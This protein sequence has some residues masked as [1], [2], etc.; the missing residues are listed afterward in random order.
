[1][2]RINL[3]PGEKAARSR[4]TFM[5]SVPADRLAWLPRSPAFLAGLAGVAVLLVAVF[6][7]FGER[8][9]LAQA[10]A[11]VVEEQADSLQLHRSI[12]R[13]RGLEDTQAR[14]AARIEILDEVVDG[15]LYS[16]DLME[17]L[18]MMLP[19]YTWLERIDQEDLAADQL[20][21]A[22]AT[23]SNAAVTEYMRG[24]EASPQLQRVT[25][26]GVTRSDRNQ[27]PVQ[28]FTLVADFENYQAVIIA[29][30]D[31]TQGEE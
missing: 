4:R 21:L 15:R 3:V 6:L 31:T 24:L 23:F 27:V 10:E 14:L 12:V 9:S 30:P 17:T 5:P 1:M 18:S 25:L 2:V 20:R 29:P 28:S 19:D 7:Y 13:V 22:G 8:R 11:A 16:I 26:V